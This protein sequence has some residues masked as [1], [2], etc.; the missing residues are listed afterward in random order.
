M[1]PLL[2]AAQ[3]ATQAQNLTADNAASIPDE[4]TFDEAVSSREGTVMKMLINSQTQGPASSHQQILSSD[5]GTVMMAHVGN[6]EHS[7]ETDINNMMSMEDSASRA[8][9]S[10]IYGKVVPSRAATLTNSQMAVNDNE[11]EGADY[12]DDVHYN[13][14][15]G[16]GN[17]IQ[18]KP[19]EI[20]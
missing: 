8:K 18:K 2:T 1:E 20:N 5:A 6:N 11:A 13:T 10:D 4:N 3:M 19:G 14:A 7:M 15:D 9:D 16:P 17:A 12:R